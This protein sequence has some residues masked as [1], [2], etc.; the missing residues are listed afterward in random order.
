MWSS[1]QRQNTVFIDAEDEGLYKE[2]DHQL[3]AKHIEWYKEARALNARWDQMVREGR[4]REACEEVKA[5]TESIKA[6]RE[7]RDA[8]RAARKGVWSTTN[9]VVGSMYGYAAGIIPR[10]K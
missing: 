1:S 7:E 5:Y 8:A 9:L 2:A 6:Y 3:K 10:D 4:T